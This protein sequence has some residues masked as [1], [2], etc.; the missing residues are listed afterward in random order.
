MVPAFY[1]QVVAKLVVEPNTGKRNLEISL[2]IVKEICTDDFTLQAQRNFDDAV[3]T[4]VNPQCTEKDIFDKLV[5]D[6]DN[7]TKPD[8]ELTLI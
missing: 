2:D 5:P 4:C 1:D 3:N 7:S 6:G 8:N